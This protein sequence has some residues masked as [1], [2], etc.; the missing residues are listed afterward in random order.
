MSLWKRILEAV[1]RALTLTEPLGALVG[2]G[3]SSGLGA[4]APT[5]AGQSRAGQNE[6]GHTGAEP[7]RSVAFTIAVIALAAKMARADG[8]VSQREVAAFRRLFRVPAAEERN[9]AR[10]FD[11]AKRHTHGFESYARQIARMLAGYPEVLEKVLDAL[12]AIAAADSGPVKP[13][14]LAYLRRVAEIFGY[15]EA[16]FARFRVLAGA[17]PQDDPYSVLGVPPDTPQPELRRQHRSLVA[18]YHP[19]RLMGLGLPP[20]FVTL[21]TEK[22]ARI[23]AAYDLVRQDRRLATATE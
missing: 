1:A 20:A 6:A 23:N 14:E 11:L 7:T 8:E 12:Y 16:R 9:L 4:S 5:G 10:V 2:I 17:D 18:R 15:D 22:L 3:S 21:A 13:V 19:D